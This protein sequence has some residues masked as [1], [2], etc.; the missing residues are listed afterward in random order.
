[1]KVDYKLI[2]IICCIFLLNS[3]VLADDLKD[4]D[5]LK[6]I[7]IRTTTLYGEYRGETD[8]IYIIEHAGASRDTILKSD[9]HQVYRYQSMTKTGFV[10]GSMIG[11]F[12]GIAL[13][14][15]K[16]D[17]V[18]AR[19][20]AGT[21]CVSGVVGGIIGV[22][23][24]TPFKKCELHRTFRD[25]TGTP[26]LAYRPIGKKLKIL[27]IDD[28][29]IEGVFDSTHYGELRI[30]TKH[31]DTVIVNQSDITKVYQYYNYTTIGTV[32]GVAAG[33][34]SA[35]YVFDAFEKSEID[36]K[37]WSEP[38]IGLYLIGSGIVGGIWGN[39]IEGYKEIQPFQSSVSF[40]LR[41]NDMK[42]TMFCVSLRF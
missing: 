12:S 8:Q 36:S 23:V 28:G 32:I 41:Q 4:G 6:I 27:T 14:S 5:E 16:D 31:K 17:N 38:T 25:Q 37:E 29:I 13:S 30:I 33:A 11:V 9:I 40:E 26:H 34:L 19:T 7:T 20:H 3:F 21:I 18:S 2:S 35:V 42:Q 15:K 39:Q 1:M 10:A 22:A 24:T